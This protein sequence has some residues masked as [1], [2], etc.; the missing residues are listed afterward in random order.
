MRSIFLQASIL[1]FSLL[2]S[3][4]VFCQ[5]EANQTTIVLSLDGFRWDYP[6]KT[7]TPYLDS[8]AKH[9]VKA[10]SLIPS[11]PSK[12]F[13]N[14]YTLATGLVPDHHGL[15]NNTFY[16]KN[17]NATYAIGNKETRYNPAF[18]KGEPIWVTAHKQGVK[19]ASYYWVGSDLPIQGIQP[20][21]WKEYDQS[22]SFVERI[23]TI[24]Q[25]LQ[26]PLAMRPKL[27]MAY[28][29][30]PDGIGHDF[31]PNHS[32]TLHMIQHL[33]SLV[34]VLCSK[35]V[36]L[37]NAESI[38]LIVLSDHGMGDISS[39]KHIVLREYIPSQW[40]VKIEGGNPNFNFYA[41]AQ[42]VDSCYQKLKKVKYISVWKP[43]EVPLELNYGTNPLVGDL[44]VVADSGCAVSLHKPGLEYSKGT[45]GY[46]IRNS[47]MHA[48]FY[49]IGPAFKTNYK[50][51]S[52]SNVNIYSLL[53]YLIGVQPA[54]NDGNF[55]AVEGMLKKE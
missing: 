8:I 12:T 10:A 46:D 11:F 14:H 23:D 42:W 48:I 2:I 25:W 1:C 55:T 32:A 36:A 26:K 19:T 5:A 44:I 3:S 47:D 38:N 24:V 40:P 34:G 49:A 35:I 13:P 51:P 4:E 52:F 45:H 27:V 31:G 28:Y 18:Y 53:S 41:D 37:K 33:D 9:G 39:E 54:E 6:Q 21:Y 20:D 17:L 15:V 30:E 22:V 50:H 29:H 16:D 43:G 7:N